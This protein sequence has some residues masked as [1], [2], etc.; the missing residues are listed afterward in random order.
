[1]EKIWHNFPQTFFVKYSPYIFPRNF[2]KSVWRNAFQEKRSTHVGRTMN[3][4]LR[5]VVFH[6]IFHISTGRNFAQKSRIVS[7]KYHSPERI[8]KR[9][10]AECAFGIPTPEF[11][12]N[13]GGGVESSRA[14]CV[15]EITFETTLWKLSKKSSPCGKIHL[16]WKAI[17]LILL[18]NKSRKRY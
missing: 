18:D 17:I 15:K 6:L 8:P 4:H 16:S 13:F 7:S 11:Y 2:S 10:R 14:G 5:A 3:I 1:M 12:G 9:E